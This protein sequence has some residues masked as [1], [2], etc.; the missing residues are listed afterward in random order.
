M[1]GKPGTTRPV[2]SSYCAAEWTTMSPWHDRMTA[3]SSTQLGRVREQ[4]GDLDAALAVLP[5]RPLRAEQPG[6]ALDEL[7]LGLAE[8]LRAAAGRRA[9]SAAAWGRTS[10]GGSGP[11]A[12]NRKM[13]DLR[14]RRQV[15]AASGASGSAGPARACS[16]WSSEASAR[17]PKPQKAS[18]TN[19]R[20]V[21]VGR[22]WGRRASRDIEEPV[23]VE[24][25]QG[26]LLRRL[27]AEE[28]ERDR[29]LLRASAA[30]RAPG[31]RRGRRAG[32]GRRPASRA[33]R[34]ANARGQV[35]REPAVEQLQRLGGVG[36]R[37]PPGAARQQRRGVERLEERQP[38]VPLGDQVDRPP[39]VLVAG[40]RRPAT[41]RACRG[42][43]PAP[44][45]PAPSR[46][47]RRP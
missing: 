16:S 44:G 15:R 9:C 35:V 30:G 29:P 28:R 18:R 43:S 47:A 3:R 41:A 21:R 37:L 23:Q 13:T 40:S 17:P 22:E 20:R 42:A 11:P 10:R 6:V 25:G 34:R 32:P 26:E 38:Q 33:S 2:N 27:V 36:A 24:H 8:L 31:G 14:L 19:S 45:R 12:M 4:V 46:S 1:L 39:V 5:E 7:V